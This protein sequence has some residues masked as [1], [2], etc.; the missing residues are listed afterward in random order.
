VRRDRATDIRLQCLRESFE[1][2]DSIV[3]DRAAIA[4]DRTRAGIAAAL[5][6]VVGNNHSNEGASHVEV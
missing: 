4:A 3:D 2:V 1:R 5:A 6:I